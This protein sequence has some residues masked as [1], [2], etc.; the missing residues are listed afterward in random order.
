MNREVL[1]KVEAFDKAMAISLEKRYSY[2]SNKWKLNKEYVA[3][4]SDQPTYYDDEEITP[5]MF[6]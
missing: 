5:E 2:K 6:P 4:E 1:K 3:E